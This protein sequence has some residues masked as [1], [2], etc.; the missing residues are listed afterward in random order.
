MKAWWAMACLAI[1]GLSFPAQAQSLPDYAAVTQIARDA[2]AETG[3]KGLAIA[4]IDDGKVASVQALGDRNAAGDQL[5]TDTIMYGASITKTVFAYAVM[6]LVDQ[7]RMTLDTPIATM[8]AKPLPDYG[9]PDDYGNWGDLAG[10]DRWRLITPRHVLTHSTGFANFAFLEPDGKL[11]IHFDPGTHYGYSGEGIELLQFGVDVGLGISTADLIQRGVF[12]PLGM[13]RTSLMWRDDFA[14]NLADGWRIDGSVEPHDSR[15]TVRAAGSMDTTI[16]DL[17]QF[18]AALV[19][20]RGMSPAAR[21]EM[22]RGQLAI[23][24]RTQFPSL[25]AD[26][27]LSERPMASAGLGVVTFEGPQGRGFYK[28]GHNDW[29]ANTMVCLEAGKRCVLILANDVRAEAAFPTIVKAVLGDTGV[30]F[31]WEYGPATSD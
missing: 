21:A 2:M 28:G 8:L 13:T 17:A 10:D 18:V 24:T 27:P 9:N 6:Q 1:P 14:A 15:G 22:T 5:T 4:V 30:P 31:E 26:V 12:D 16:A 29:T 23:T 3:A 25:Q 20:G 11:R 7:G 19:A